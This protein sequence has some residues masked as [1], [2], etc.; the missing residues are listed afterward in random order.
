MKSQNKGAKNK[1]RGPD[2]I[3]LSVG[4]STWLFSN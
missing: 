1:I 2:D 3:R 4:T